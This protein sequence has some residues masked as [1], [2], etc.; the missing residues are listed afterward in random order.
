[1]PRSD[2]LEQPK[3]GIWVMPDNQSTGC[4]ED[5]LQNL[6]GKDDKL[7]AHAKDFVAGLPEKRFLNNKEPEES[8]F[9]K[10]HR[11]KAIMHT[12]L[13]WQEEP[14]KPFGQSIT[15][16]YLDPNLPLGQTFAAWLHKLF[17]EG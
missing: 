1:M 9:N 10:I 15:A 16:H 7:H 14:G 4:L 6:I 13:A 5:F 17:F 12:W 11:S 2:S 8:E 3:V